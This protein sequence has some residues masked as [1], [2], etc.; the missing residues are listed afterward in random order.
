VTTRKVTI[1]WQGLG[2]GGTPSATGPVLVLAAHPDDEALG[3]AGIIDRAR[4]Q[5]RRVVVVLATNGEGSQAE[6]AAGD[7][8]APADA[9]PAARYARLRDIETRD[10]LG[11][12]GLN[13]STNLNTTGIIFLGYPGGRLVDVAQAETTAMT[14]SVTGVQRTFAEDFDASVTTCNGDYRYLRTGQHAQFLASSLRGDLDALLAG[15]APTDI[16]THSTFDGHPD[17][18]E[19]TRQLYSAV[20]RSNVPVRVHSTLMHPEGDTNCMGLSSARWPNPVLANNNPFARFTPTLNFSIPPA[21][22]C[23]INDASTDWGPFGAPNESVD[24]PASMQTTSEATNKKWQSISKYA[25]QVDC[26]NPDE[27][28]VSCGYMRAFVKKNEFFWKYDFGSK[29]IWPKTYTTNWTSN[30]SIAQQAQILEGQWRYE[31]GGVRPLTTGFDRALIVGDM[32]W[33]DY[34]IRMPFTINSFDPTTPQGAAVGLGVGWQGHTAWGQPRHGHPSGG[35]CVYTRGGSDPL[36]FR[37]QIG[38]SPG[39]VDDATLVTQDRALAP[40]VPYLMR[41]QQKGVSAGLTRYSCKVWRASQAEPAAWDLTTDIPDWPGTT[42]QRA[43]S[44]VLLAHEADATF[45]NVQF[46]PAD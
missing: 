36:P 5:G 1:N 28:H 16:Y 24:V 4:S 38:Y 8:G 40:G 31:N 15:V 11:V 13:W 23:D 21:N 34:E 29:R 44:T 14:N 6:S 45:G 10:G 25:S 27:Y 19:L 20:R 9:A 18:A 37:L 12:L 3:M 22:P 41:F 2:G 35:L 46:S 26:S 32:G 42:G 39:P 33:T 7:C 43:G 30:A 17:H